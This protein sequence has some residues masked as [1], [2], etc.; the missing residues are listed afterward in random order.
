MAAAIF[1]KSIIYATM[2]PMIAIDYPYVSDF[3]IRTLISEHIPVIDTPQ[4]R[5]LVSERQAEGAITFISPGEA[6]DVLSSDPSVM[7]Y[8]NSENSLSILSAADFPTALREQTGRL[9]NKV[10]FRDALRS[11]YPGFSYRSVSSNL[12]STV[13]PHSL[14]YPCVVKPAVGFFS[15]GV[16]LLSSPRQWQEYVTGYYGDVSWDN[17][18]VDTS[19]CIIEECIEGDEYAIDCYYTPEGKPVIMGIFR[20]LFA[21]ADDVSDRV[22]ITSAAIVE[23]Q[24]E[25]FRAF[26][27]TVGETFDLRNFPVHA[28]VRISPEHGIIPIEINPLRFGGW[29]TTADFSQYAYGYNQYEYYFGRK[30]P[31]WPAIIQRM[32]RATYSL[33][34]LDNSTGIPVDAIAGFD[35]EALLATLT[36]PLEFREIDYRKHG[37]F[38]FVFAR[39]EDPGLDELHYLLQS[40][41][42][43]FTLV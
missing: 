24:L 11:R 37:V 16:T 28:E 6:A 42:K 8:T 31:D 40:D 43:E 30:K 34:V 25:R 27:A 9:K 7:L 39:C 2:L 26:L 38:G 13:D 23:E 3:L 35:A 10:L 18:V 17:H 19:Y 41:L 20:H 5:Y 22:Y 36:E 15:V 29:C 32:G 14:S 33:I 1:R 4:S 21:S 12:L